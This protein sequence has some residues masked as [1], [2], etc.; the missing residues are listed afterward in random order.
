MEYLKP[1]QYYIDR[2]DLHTIEECLDYYWSIKDRFAKE[3]DSHFARY[4]QA[5]FEQEMNKCLNLMLFTL[6]GMRYTHKKETI[7][8]WMDRD[9]RMQ[10]LYDNTHAPNNVLC[11][12]CGHSTI[13]T[14][15]DLHDSYEPNA[16]MTFMFECTKCKKRQALFE[17]GT[18]W[19]YDPPKCP[20]CNHALKTDLEIKDD[21]T[22]FT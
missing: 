15:K 18:E 22:T 21:I 17:D 20:K 11:K 6:K 19:M 1:E 14:S 4:T 12:I 9:R 10:E 2:Y 3:K 7:Q 5:K 16:R 13:V 8:E